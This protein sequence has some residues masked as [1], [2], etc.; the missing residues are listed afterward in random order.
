MYGHIKVFETTEMTS[1]N[2]KFGKLRFSRLHLGSVQNSF[3]K[4]SWQKLITKTKL[5]KTNVNNTGNRYN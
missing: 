4:N 5:W 3:G 2:S 1:L